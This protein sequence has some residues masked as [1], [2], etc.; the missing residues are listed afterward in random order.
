MRRW[1]SIAG[2]IWRG[3][4]YLWLIMLSSIIG[5]ILTQAVGL[6]IVLLTGEPRW[7]THVRCAGWTLF[8]IVAAALAIGAPDVIERFWYTRISKARDVQRGPQTGG[9]DN[10]EKTD[11]GSIRIVRGIRAIPAVCLIGGF[12]GLIAGCMLSGMFVVVYFFL[13][14]SPLARDGWWPLLPWYAVGTGDGFIATGNGAPP[15]YIFLLI[16]GSTMLLLIAVRFTGSW[17]SGQTRYAVFGSKA[18]R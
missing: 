15:A 12:V 9:D 3:T 7:A 16:F 14:L 4:R 11:D 6:G 13:A 5:A 8:G 17:S 2:R 18:K 10:K 1:I